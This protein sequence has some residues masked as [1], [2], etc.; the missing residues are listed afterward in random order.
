MNATAVRNIPL[1]QLELSMN[2]ARTTSATPDSLDELI[3]SIRTHGILQNLVVRD[4]GTRAKPKYSVT[5][6]GRRLQALRGLAAEGDIPDNHPVACRVQPKK[7]N[8]LVTATNGA[9]NDDADLELSLH[10]NTVR[11]GMHPADQFEAYKRLI[12]QGVR[13]TDIANRF[14][15]TEHKV[16]Q[17]LRLADCAPQLINAFR[18][19]DITLLLLS[20]FTITKDHEH[21]LAVWE[22]VRSLYSK[23]D[24]ENIKHM[25]TE[26]DVQATSSAARLVGIEAYEAAGGL[27]RRDLFAEEDDRG[28]YLQDNELLDRLVDERL[29]AKA[30]ELLKDGWR[31]T[32]VERNLNATRLY[33]WHTVEPV[34]NGPSG[35]EA[36]RLAEVRE[37]MAAI[38]NG[39]EFEAEGGR[40]EYNALD[41]E[42][43]ELEALIAG[44][45]GYRDSD[46]AIAG[47]M[48][49]LGAGGEI[50]I[51]GGL[52]RK[53]DVPKAQPP[54][55]TPEPEPEPEP[56]GAVPTEAG[57]EATPA[58]A[59]L[60]TSPDDNARTSQ[61][62][63]PKPVPTPAPA[64]EP[65]Q[66]RAPMYGN[67]GTD[68]HVDPDSKARKDAGVG[69][70][71]FDDLRAVR[72]EAIKD[73]LA[74][75]PQAAFDLLLF[76][77]AG[78]VL[79]DR[80]HEKA[81]NVTAQD[82]DSYPYRPEAKP[83]IQ[84]ALGNRAA[85]QKDL[86]LPL[87]YQ[88]ARSR[89]RQF[90]LLTAMHQ[91]EKMRLL[92][93]CVAKCLNPQLAFEP[94]AL[95]DIEATVE[96]L[97]ID[98]SKA[99]RPTLDLYWSRVT[100]DRLLKIAQETLGTDWAAAHKGD[101]KPELAKAVELAFQVGETPTGVQPAAHEAAVAWAMPGFRPFDSQANP[102]EPQSGQNAPQP[103][104]NGD[105]GASEPVNE[106]PETRYDFQDPPESVDQ[107]VQTEESET[108]PPFME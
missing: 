51:H 33:Q 9:S 30:D 55:P 23:P 56:V 64:P 16:K 74:H 67:E 14:G 48:V 46:K 86:N 82:K 27:V 76:Q 101:S 50:E 43:A 52:V 17:L 70:S 103:A 95:A 10:E 54:A 85:W 94:N 61:P 8:N 19:N 35:T 39:T 24:P 2:N 60:E 36:N 53:E 44:H 66:V 107:P 88:R 26:G 80:Y 78:S 49:S 108:L 106:T 81:L 38:E 42:H 32:Q 18:S 96:R 91:D 45:I 58:Q 97:G 25:L 71:L 65:P 100:K 29:Q 92:A 6:G 72:T 98:F 79:T 69:A 68:K 5:A 11:L 34:S 83:V 13:L 104:G 28:I 87:Q 63:S 41:T 77:M 47:C 12:D 99:T 22:R 20:A 62:E 73:R 15:V 75:S 31:W 3:A 21:Q 37:R 93:A 59:E 40:A 1:N 89:R 102:D 90:E 7:V 84:E 57:R 4:A 105:A